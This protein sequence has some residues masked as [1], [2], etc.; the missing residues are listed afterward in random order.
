MERYAEEVTQTLRTYWRSPARN[1]TAESIAPRFFSDR[2]AGRQMYS[3]GEMLA[4][5]W[6]RALRAKKPAGLDGLL[7]GLLL[8]PDQTAQAEPARERVLRALTSELGPKPREQVQTYIVEG[9]DLDL[10]ENLAGPCFALGW[11]DVPRWMLGFDTASFSKRSATGVVPDGPAHKAGLRDGMLLEGWSVYGGDVS[12]EVELMVKIDGSS[13]TLRYSPV[14]GSSERLPL[15]A[16][17][18]G[19][20]TDAGCQGWIRR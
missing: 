20:G 19:A 11:V 2:D 12:K 7:R 15:L 18:A 14:D 4:M 6:D 3:R 9:R 10:D 8:A 16:V 1:A 5:G 13:K 17:R